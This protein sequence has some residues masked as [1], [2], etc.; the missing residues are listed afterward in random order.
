M[1]DPAET[2]Y[3]LLIAI[4]RDSQIADQIAILNRDYQDVDIHWV[5]AD[6]DRT[7]NSAWYDIIVSNGESTAQTEM[8]TALRKG[9]AGDFNV[10]TV[11][12]VS[13]FVHT[14]AC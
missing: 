11:G 14:Y 10:Y 1:Y 2:A 6:T 7:A 4:V 5:L 8:K 12:C 13:Q 3:L 9:G